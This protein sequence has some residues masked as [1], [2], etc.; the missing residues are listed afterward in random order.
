MALKS[1]LIED[2]IAIRFQRHQWYL[3]FTSKFLFF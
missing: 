1:T 2:L 3:I